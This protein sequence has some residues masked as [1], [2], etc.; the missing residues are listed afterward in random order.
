MAEIDL[1]SF[2]DKGLLERTIRR[3]ENLKVDL[4]PDS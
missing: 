4:L 2:K 3:I 1:E